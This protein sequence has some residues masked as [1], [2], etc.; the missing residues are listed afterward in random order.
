MNET[1]PSELSENPSVDLSTKQS[2]QTEKNKHFSSK[3]FKLL[4][5]SFI[6]VALVGLGGYILKIRKN[7]STTNWETLSY[8]DK[9]SYIVSGN[10]YKRG[11]DFYLKYHLSLKYPP[12]WFINGP[13]DHVYSDK[14]CY[15]HS[16]VDSC[17]QIILNKY[18]KDP[19]L[20]LR[21][22]IQ[23][24]NSS[25]KEYFFSSDIP[26]NLNK[27]N[28]LLTKESLNSLIS[29]NIPIDSKNYFSIEFSNMEY[30]IV[31]KILPTIQFELHKEPYAEFKCEK[32]AVDKEFSITYLL[33]EG[34]VM[35]KHT[36]EHEFLNSE[37]CYKLSRYVAEKDGYYLNIV[38]D[39]VLGTGR[40]RC[41]G[42]TTIQNKS[43]SNRA[44]KI[45]RSN[46]DIEYRSSGDNLSICSNWVT[47]D[48]LDY[49]TEIFRIKY[50]LPPFWEDLLLHEM[51][52]IVES[53]DVVSSNNLDL[54][55][56]DVFS[57]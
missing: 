1:P 32:T 10:S 31:K 48:N 34:W 57:D 43:L 7:N 15:T 14:E 42:N 4:I 44:T 16:H 6:V 37:N 36:Y 50:D 30:E 8:T 41:E 49:D 18:P 29:I 46:P 38:S 13:N 54:L 12:N 35:N 56:P 26:D 55:Y 23:P 24:D 17:S 20:D 53:I 9:A 22:A 25:N 19:N 40:A 39:P 21:T 52:L 45:L 33:P 47:S 27:L 5:V 2:L 51:D 11:V 3:S 28:A